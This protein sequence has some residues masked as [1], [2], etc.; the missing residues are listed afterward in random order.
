MKVVIHV[1]YSLADF[2]HSNHISI[3]MPSLT[4]LIII[5]FPFWISILIF[6]NCRFTL[7]LFRDGM[8]S[9][10]ICTTNLFHSRV[11]ETD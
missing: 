2:L 10:G 6:V 7:D 11:V 9:F 8:S 4:A 1:S 5:V 3:T